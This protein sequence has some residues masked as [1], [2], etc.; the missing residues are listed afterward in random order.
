MSY[1]SLLSI[2][3]SYITQ[4]NV[5]GFTHIAVVR[6]SSN[7]ISMYFNG[8]QVLTPVTNSIALDAGTAQTI[9]IGGT[10]MS[11]QVNTTYGYIDDLRITKGFC[12]YN[13]Q[14]NINIINISKYIKWIQKQLKIV[15]KKDLIFIKW[16]IL[17]QL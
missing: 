3:N 14:F 13:N 7:Y 16:M 15:Y 2:Y 9:Y 6:N 12:R 17:N 11:S 8:I 4:Y 1:I 5:N 10:N